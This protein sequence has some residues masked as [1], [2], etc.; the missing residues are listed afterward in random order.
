[1]QA[2]GQLTIHGQTKDIAVP[3]ELLKADGGLLLQTEF[4]VTVEDFGVS[5]P[6]AVSDKIAKEAKVTLRAN[7][8]KR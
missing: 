5:I 7:L 3:C 6:G 4:P 2:V 8:K 1:G